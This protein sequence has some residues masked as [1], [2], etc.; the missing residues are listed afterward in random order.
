[1]RRVRK[2]WLAVAFSALAHAFAAPAFAAD[3]AVYQIEGVRLGMTAKEVKKQMRGEAEKSE[4]E[5]VGEAGI[6]RETFLRSPSRLEVTYDAG[7]ASRSR[8]MAVVNLRF[9]P[10]AAS[11]EEF[12]S[13]LGPPD[14]GEEHLG[15]G[16][17]NGAV[18]WLEESCGVVVTA[19]RKPAVWWQGGAD[20]TVVE[21]E[22][23]GR[24]R[25]REGSPAAAAIAAWE[26]SPAESW[27]AVVSLQPAGGVAPADAV[28]SI[29]FEV[30]GPTTV[31]A[32]RVYRAP[33]RLEDSYV[34]PRYPRFPAGPRVPG[35][36]V[37]EVTIEADGSVGDIAVRS[38]TPIARGF[39]GAA[40]EAVRKWRYRPGTLDGVPVQAKVTVEMEFR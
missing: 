32:S 25:E 19:D 14:A 6:V 37:L 4:R 29:P 28:P 7:A 35:R 5:G 18:V 3:C 33:E 27:E 9:F 40:Q 23:W 39:E 20:S 2:P 15:D 34:P 1:M 13:L 22:T 17:V 12:F 30:P 26:M 11:A 8:G 10:S 16:A 21:I 38:V 24:A 36:V 31:E